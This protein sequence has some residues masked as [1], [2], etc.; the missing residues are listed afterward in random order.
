MMQPPAP[1]PV[2]PKDRT[3]LEE[4]RLRVLFDNLPVALA[5]LDGDGAILDVNP[6]ASAL[7]GYGRQELLGMNARDLATDAD[8]L[9][10]ERAGQLIAER[11]WFTAPFTGIR[12]DGTTFPEETTLTFGEVG[13][14]SVIFCLVRDMSEPNRLNAEII[15]LTDLAR[16][17][18][19][20][21][22]LSGIAR[23]AVTVV[24]RALHA[25]RAAVGRF[26]DDGRLEWLANYRMEEVQ[27]ALQRQDQAEAVLP[28]A[29]VLASGRSAFVDRRAPDFVGGVYQ[30]LA[31]RLETTAYALIPVRAGD[32]LTGLLGLMWTGD[33]P[34]HARYPILLDT[35]GRLVGMAIAN[36][37]LRDSLV[38]RTAQLDE[39]EERY[40]TL[41]LEAPEP[42]LIESTEGRVADANRA[43]ERLYR[44]ARAEILGREA[45]E[46]IRLSI[47]DGDELPARLLAERHRI[48]RG[49]GTRGDGGVFPAEVEIAVIVVQGV[50][51]LLLQVR[52]LTD[53]ERLQAELLQAQKMEAL[54]H[55]VS[56]VAHELNNPLSA[57]VAFS[58]LLRRDERLPDELRHDADLL[59]QEA[60]RTR[61]IVQ[62]LL[63]FARQRPPERRPSSVRQLVDRTLQLH[64]YALGAARIDVE[65]EVPEDLP[66]IDV[67]SNQIQQ[68][69]LNLTL[70]AIQA[71]RA[72]GGPG[73]LMLS[74]ASVAEAKGGGGFVR[75]RVSDDG[76]GVRP[77]A[78]RHLFT[79]FYTT[80]PVG[81]GTGLGLS[82]SFG[83]VAAHG[84][85]LWFE[86]RAEGGSHFLLELPVAQRPVRP[87]TTE[88]VGGERASLVRPQR[89]GT[90]LAVDDEPAIRAFLAR[91]LGAAGHVVTTV[92][93]GDEALRHL[94]RA[95]VDVLLVD[96][97]LVG[98]DGI[99]TY[100]EALRLRPHLRRRTI[101]MSGDALDPTLQ[102]FVRKRKLTLLAKPFDLDAVLRAVDDALGE[103]ALPD[104]QVRGPG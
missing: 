55:L 38:A 89:R 101:V 58:Q 82:V 35:I 1:S 14:R 69:L 26:L 71:L 17:H 8:S 22:D 47:T 42:L 83:I 45:R 50:E 54:G 13:G 86:P 37:Q 62:N 21:Q 48:L 85:R 84:G 60:D 95:P 99:A 3:L 6:A 97:R 63:D 27:A 16:L 53:Q 46:L 23:Q 76:P 70:N 77:E 41:F 66:R 103:D 73:R 43:A 49:T 91:T 11:G 79:P 88:A 39:S 29:E 20:G 31:D 7:F 61:R 2:S 98:M 59:V 75:L 56:G 64:A 94:R 19:S 5:V 74:A 15:S 32:L 81:E 65:L 93:S 104:G 44:L 36:A 90:V 33:P 24:R 30:D 57:I 72:R 51:Q 96:R 28:L 100:L 4:A 67:D 34:E 102:A 9:P 10:V 52:D 92:A 68:V 80:K 40:R 18:E 87:S 12:A 25:D 78:R